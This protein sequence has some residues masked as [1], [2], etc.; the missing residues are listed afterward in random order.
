MQCLAHSKRTQAQCR[1]HAL[2]GRQVCRL[3]GGKSPIGPGSAT[4]RTG[5]F[6]KFLPSRMAAE[7]EQAKRDPALLD[8]RDAIA[9]ADARLVDLLQRVDTG[10]AGIRWTEAQE[11]LDAFTAA[12]VQGDTEGMR[13]ALYTMQEAIRQGQSDYAAWHEVALVIEQRRKLVDSEHK[14]LEAAHE[15]L[16][17]DRAML[18]LGV[19]VQTIQRHVTDRSV[20]SA[21][22]SDLQGSVLQ[23]QLER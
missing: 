19:V 10:E 5:R 17:I 15:I 23:G 7:F 2:R 18:L 21:I 12:Q 16:S 4:F 9:L 14:H 1:R 20:L 11:A 6:S 13:G 22:A 3:H 8:L